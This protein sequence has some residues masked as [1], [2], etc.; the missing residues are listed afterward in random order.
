MPFPISLS[1]PGFSQ[2]IWPCF[3]PVTVHSRSFSAMIPIRP[4]VITPFALM[5][6]SSYQKMGPLHTTVSF[7]LNW[8]LPLSLLLIC[9]IAF[10]SAALFTGQASL[11]GPGTSRYMSWETW[12][13]FDTHVL[14]VLA[15]WGAILGGFILFTNWMER[16]IV[17]LVLGRMV[18]CGR[19]DCRDRTSGRNDRNSR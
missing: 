13:Q 5:K 10:G 17:G 3:K 7:R 15:I 8:L 19:E 6:R 14:R 11:D 9:L 12:K 16:A 18:S 1:F 4:V 2:I